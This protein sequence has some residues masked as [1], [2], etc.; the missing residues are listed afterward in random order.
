MRFVTGLI[1]ALL[2]ACAAPP[3]NA[4]GPHWDSRSFTLAS[5]LAQEDYVYWMA[6]DSITEANA[7]RTV[8]N[9][10]P[11]L[12]VGFGGAGVIELRARLLDLYTIETP[13]HLLV[14][15]GTNDSHSAVADPNAWRGNL[16]GIV[17]D[18]TS[19]GI[20]VT[21]AKSP[22]L[23]WKGMVASGLIVPQGIHAVR[24]QVEV[25]GN[26]WGIPYFDP[27]APMFPN[28]TTDGVHLTPAAYD[29]LNADIDE[30]LC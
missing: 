29:Q 3:A 24:Q 14:M 18:A 12:N 9:G 19:R 21:L 13:Q 26:A 6:G 27:S 7:R 8:C 28:Y 4:W 11:I 17:T 1:F 20:S 25:L 10:Q 23:E 22:L 30:A 15:I 16:G 2:F 5:Q